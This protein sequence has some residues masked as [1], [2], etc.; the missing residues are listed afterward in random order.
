MFIPIRVKQVTMEIREAHPSDRPAIRDVARRSMQA[1]YPLDPRA[2]VGAVEEWYDEDRVREMLSDDGKLLLVADRD[3]QVVGFSDSV[4]TGEDTAEVLWLHVDPDYRGDDVGAA[5][6]D[7]TRGR[8]AELDASRL[9][10]RVL[11]DNTDGNAFY[12]ERGLTKVDEGEV[13]IDGTAYV[14]NVYAEADADPM[15]E[16]TLGD[17]T[18]VFVDR[19]NEETGSLAPFRIVYT[20]PDRSEAYGYWCAKCESLANA[21][22]AS[23]RIQ[24]DGCGNARKPT[25]WDAAYL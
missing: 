14:E 2:I 17:D 1:S 3:D 11:A 23:G 7:E 21:M 13:D 9:R 12:E 22:D 25:R 4:L 10:G 15:E 6:F 18:S 5:L 24:C 8:L 16:I 19:A 20:D